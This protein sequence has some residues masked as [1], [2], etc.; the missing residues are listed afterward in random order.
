MLTTLVVSNEKLPTSLGGESMS[1]IEYPNKLKIDNELQILL[2]T[3]V[4][5]Y[6]GKLIINDNQI[7]CFLFFS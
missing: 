4:K 6:H 1:H 3:V 5:K 2:K 7:K